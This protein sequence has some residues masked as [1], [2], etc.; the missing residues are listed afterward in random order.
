MTVSTAA[1]LYILG[2]FVA[3]NWVFLLPK[4]I[5]LRI[6]STLWFFTLLF[7]LY[8]GY[9]LDRYFLAAPHQLWQGST[10]YAVFIFISLLMS[11]IGFLYQKSR[12]KSSYL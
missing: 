5:S 9:W 8:G 2:W 6:Q 12:K 4:R 10:I 1:T 3:C 7:V 11:T